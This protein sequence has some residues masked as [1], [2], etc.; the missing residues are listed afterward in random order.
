MRKYKLRQ[1]SERG[2]GKVLKWQYK[3]YF[4]PVFFTSYIT[5]H[6]YV[7]YMD[8]NILIVIWAKKICGK[9]WAE[10][11]INRRLK[12]TNVEEA[13]HTLDA[14]FEIFNCI[15]NWFRWNGSIQMCIALYYI[16]LYLSLSLFF[17][18][19]IVQILRWFS[20]HLKHNNMHFCSEENWI[21][22]LHFYLHLSPSGFFFLFPFHLLD[23]SFLLGFLLFRKYTTPHN[24]IEYN[25]MR[26][27]IH[28]PFWNALH[29]QEKKKAKGK[30]A[31]SRSRR[32]R[33]KSKKDCMGYGCFLS[34]ICFCLCLHAHTYTNARART[35]THTQS[36]FVSISF[37]RLKL[38]NEIKFAWLYVLRISHNIHRKC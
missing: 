13:T 19:S 17:F 28:V 38:S 25:K 37:F 9:V 3:N 34:C 20:M 12:I 31:R 7:V 32:T 22:S 16:I 30:R 8:T 21:F 23:V 36:L 6:L 10:G 15:S 2:K 27:R 5:I 33:K 4:C 11:S 26:I 18:H 1:R 29:T 14:K 35:R 24:K